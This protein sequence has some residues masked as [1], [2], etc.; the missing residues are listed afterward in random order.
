MARGNNKRQASIKVST[1]EDVARGISQ[2]FTD[3]QVDKLNALSKEMG[4][5]SP[6]GPKDYEGIPER[7][8]FVEKNRAVVDL[9]E[10]HYGPS[11]AH[12]LKRFLGKVANTAIYNSGLVS[13]SMQ[14]SFEAEVAKARSRIP[15]MKRKVYDAYVKKTEDYNVGQKYGAK[16]FKE[17]KSF[18]DYTKKLPTF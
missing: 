8:A 7:L 17:V 16:K 15:Q 3:E 5:R 4:F 13:G 10:K 11:E 14:S 12:E 9:I 6:I 2:D 18:E 1:R